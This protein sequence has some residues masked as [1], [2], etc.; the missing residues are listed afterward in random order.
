MRDDPEV[1]ALVD[2]ARG[3]DA[4]AWNALVVRYAPL[5]WSVCRRFHLSDADALDVGQTVWLRL[6]EHLPRLRDPAALPG[7]IISTTRHEC[8][9]FVR[10]ERRDSDTHQRSAAVAEADPESVE[11]LLLSHERNEALRRAFGRLSERCQRLL[12]ALLAEPPRNYA[13]IAD[14]LG[15]PRGSL[16]PRRARCLAE[17]RR[18]PTLA[19]V[20]SKAAG[21]DRTDRDDGHG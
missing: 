19:A 12:R 6:V 10:I 20:I 11:E 3:G 7:W 4:Q 18:D 21:D 16:G 17:L 15:M 1:I 5:V 2:G 8:L 9:R 14:E 13:S